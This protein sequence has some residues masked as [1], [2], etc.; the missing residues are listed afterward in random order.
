[1]GR[2]ALPLTP[3]V[4]MEKH[5]VVRAW[6]D[7]KFR[8]SLSA[9]QR[10]ALPALPAGERV[11]DMADEQLR[12]VSGGVGTGAFAT[13]SGDCTGGISCWRILFGPLPI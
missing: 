8:A 10:A 13:F 11:A 4:S 5:D 6:K 7:P 3:T 1:M 2:R 12:N 9:E